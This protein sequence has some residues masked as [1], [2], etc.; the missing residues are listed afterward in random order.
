MPQPLHQH[1]WHISVG[2]EITEEFPGLWPPGALQVH[3]GSLK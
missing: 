3:A 1:A 2:H